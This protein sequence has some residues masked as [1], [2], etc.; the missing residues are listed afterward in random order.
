M[1]SVNVSITG[2]LADTPEL[3]Q[4]EA[5]R[6]VTNF[7]ILANERRFDDATQSWV[8]AHKTAVRVTAWGRLAENLVGTIGVGHEATVTGSRLTAMAYI[9]RDGGDPRA[10]LEL[11]ANSVSVELGKQTAEVAKAPKPE[12]GPA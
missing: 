8:D 9:P 5:G 10:S 3:R 1:S 11:I 7:T 2:H 6:S 12:A 4:T